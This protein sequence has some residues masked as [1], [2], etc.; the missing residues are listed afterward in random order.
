M[1]I[2]DKQ[3][4]DVMNRLRNIFGLK[5]DNDVKHFL[6]GIHNAIITGRSFAPLYEPQFVSQ[7]EYLENVQDPFNVRVM[8]THHLY[9]ISLVFCHLFVTVFDDK[10]AK[11]MQRC[12]EVSELLNGMEIVNQEVVDGKVMF[13]REKRQREVH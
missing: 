13:K 8:H 12:V 5:S 10:D 2:D 7:E 11:F 3:L 9:Q 4:D 1:M 6:A